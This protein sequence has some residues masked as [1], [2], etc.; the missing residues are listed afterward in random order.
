LD[1]RAK[2]SSEQFAFLLELERK[3][4]SFISMMSGDPRIYDLVNP[5][6]AKVFRE[7][8][9]KTP[10]MYPN[11]SGFL[12]Q[13]KDTIANFENE[14]RG[15]KY[16][17]QKIIPTTGVAS[18]LYLIQSAVLKPGDEV[19]LFSPN[20]YFFGPA[21]QV[22]FLGGSLRSIETFEEDGWLPRPEN[23]RKVLTSK[24]RFLVLV[25]PQ[26]PLGVVYAEKTL[27][28]ICDIAAEFSIPI[29]SDEIYGL[30]TF[31][32]VAHSTAKFGGENL[33]LTLS[34]VS[35]IFFATGLRCAYICI[36]GGSEK[37]EPFLNSLKKV[38]SLYGQTSTSIATPVLASVIEMYRN[39]LAS[40]EFAVRELKRRR[41]FAVKAIEGID[42]LSMIAPAGTLFTFPRVSL[43]RDF[44][45][46]F[47][48]VDALAKEER[49]GVLPG[50]MFG[51][52]GTNHIRGVILP[53]IPVQTEAYERFRRFLKRHQ[54]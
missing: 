7:A 14:K 34:G 10:F 21:D 43:P 27:K 54:T 52:G 47:A 53:E 13:F 39:H 25:N 45:D 9:Q 51:D 46:E 11:A 4:P 35:K 30:I 19:A 20:H 16:E 31:D 33:V 40:V 23:L 41:D 37:N 44:K 2:R 32:G 36:H 17:A 38:A 28:E 15:V 48:L 42:G 3:D 49:L 50:P 8:L 29:V 24:T 5:D 26:N 1:E 22:E 18:A 6:L 12:G